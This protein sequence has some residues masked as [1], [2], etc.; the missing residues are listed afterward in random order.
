VDGGKW[1]IILKHS[2]GSKWSVYYEALLKIAFRD[3]L[4]T[5]LLIE[6]TDNQVV[7]RFSIK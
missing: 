3:M 4:Q 7:A 2:A 6:K 5:D 1:T